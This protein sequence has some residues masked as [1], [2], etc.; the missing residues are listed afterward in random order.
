MRWMIVL[1][2][3]LALLLAGGTLAAQTDDAGLV[4]TVWQWQGTQMSDD[5]VFT[6][7]DPANYTVEFLADGSVAIQADCNSARASYTLDGSAI[8]ILPGPTTLMACPDGSLGSEFLAQ[9]GGAALFFFQDG[10][11]LMDLKFDSGTMRFAEPGP[12]LVGTVWQWQG[13]LMNDGSAFTPADPASYT[14]EFQ[15]DGTVSIQAD[16]NRAFASYTLDSGA[17]TILPGPTTLMACPEDSLGSEFL[18]QLGGAAIIFFQDGELLMDLKFD[19]GTMRFAA[20]PPALTGTVWLWQG[21][22]MADGALIAPDSPANYNLLFSDDGTVSIQAD[23]NRANAGYTLEDGAIAILPGPMTLMACPDGSLG[24]LF[25]EQLGNAAI[26]FFDG[27]DLLLD[28]KFDGGTMRFT[29]QPSGLAGT[30]W[31]VTAYNN[32]REAVVSLLDGTTIT[33]EFGADGSLSGSAGCNRFSTSF[34]TTADGGFSAGPTATTRMLCPTPE[35]IMEQEQA[36]IAALESAA[37]YQVRGDTLEMRTADDALAL[38]FAP[39]Q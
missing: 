4:G 32:G 29:A 33:A 37:T 5:S 10:A 26:L 25:I 28:I 20:Q 13:T 31:V 39:A 2:A 12:A 18:A 9:L 15:A 1:V 11:L 27:G 17:I 22:Q 35:G 19:S 16:C 30:A 6:P 36:F 23:C 24:T 14:V 21:T 3:A 38:M 8:T 34:Q 7:A